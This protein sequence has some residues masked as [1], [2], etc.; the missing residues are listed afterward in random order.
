MAHVHAILAGMDEGLPSSYLL[1]AKSTPVYGSDGE[2]AGRVKKVLC[3]PA[4][5]IFDGLVL[6][7]AD[8]DRC[9]PAE[10]VAAIH[11][12]GVDL[13]ITCAEVAELPAP[14]PQR[15]VKWDLDQPPPRLWEEIANWL[16]DHLPHQH[17]AHDS[18]LRHARERL[19]NRERAL[20]IASENP[21]L[22]LEAGIGRPDL[23]GA[24]HGGVVDMNHAPVEVIEALPGFDERLAQRIVDARDRISGFASLEDLGMILDLPGDQVEHLRGHVVFLPN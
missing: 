17:P 18:H 9:V 1:L 19:A 13:S 3:E 14:H 24:D 7:S 21:Q 4:A 23:P 2:E 10:R 15:R 20:T 12:R 22:A 6:A 5:D 16:L 11:A 8:G